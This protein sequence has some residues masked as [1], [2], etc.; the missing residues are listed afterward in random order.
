MGVTQNVTLL[1]D[2]ELQPMEPTE[3]DTIG[4]VTIEWG[5][6]ERSKGRGKG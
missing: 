2:G 5:T 1:I 4:D 6:E 3:K